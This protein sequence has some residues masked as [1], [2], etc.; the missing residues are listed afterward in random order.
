MAFEKA[1][2]KD[3]GGKP[4]DSGPIVVGENVLSTPTALESYPLEA[5]YMY[6]MS[7]MGFALNLDEGAAKCSAELRSGRAD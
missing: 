2:P 5:L 6:G 7:S 1:S 4:G 3:D